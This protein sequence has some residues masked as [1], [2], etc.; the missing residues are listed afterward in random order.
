M[1]DRQ[2]Q[3]ATLPLQLPRIQP[4]RGRRGRALQP[5][6]QGLDSRENLLYDALDL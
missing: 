2:A 5:G 3:V 1:A 6:R 4:R